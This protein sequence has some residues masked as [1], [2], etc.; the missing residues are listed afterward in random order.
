MLA[1][2]HTQPGNS[3][4]PRGGQ[5][6]SAARCFKTSRKSRSRALRPPDDIIQGWLPAGA[7]QMEAKGCDA[8][9]PHG[10]DP[11]LGVWPAD[12]FLPGTVKGTRLETT[13]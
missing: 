1:C 13:S 5:A 12:R 4:W 11:V 7:D 2:R 9:P 10:F 8:V 6:S 3:D